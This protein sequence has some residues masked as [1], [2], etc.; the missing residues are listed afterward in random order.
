LQEKG[1]K[2]TSYSETDG[3]GRPMTRSRYDDDE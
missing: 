3:A 1:L 2:I